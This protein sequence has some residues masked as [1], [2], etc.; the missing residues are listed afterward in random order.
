MIIPVV[1]VPLHPYSTKLDKKDKINTYFYKLIMANY[2][3]TPDTK[4][5]ICEQIIQS[6]WLIASLCAAWCNTCEAYQATFKTL[7][8]QHPALPFVWIDIEDNADLVGDLDIENFPTLLI[9]NQNTICFLGT[10]LPDINV[11][12][13]IIRTHL[14]QT[15][16]SRSNNPLLPANYNL[17]QLLQNK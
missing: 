11:A 8:E 17:R 12:A 7:S 4:H 10:V 14:I 2:T 3:L 6:D 13:R 5:L 1:K 16:I 15:K 9:Q